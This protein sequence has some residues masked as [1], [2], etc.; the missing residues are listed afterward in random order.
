MALM[1]QGL[2]IAAGAGMPAAPTCELTRLGPL[3][4]QGGTGSSAPPGG[5]SS[6]LLVWAIALIGLALMLFL[7]EV[8]VPSGGLLGVASAIS[9]VVGVVLLFWENQV[10]GLVGAIVCLI[11]LPFLL[12]F[13]LKMWPNTPIGRVLMLSAPPSRAAPGEADAPTKA[14]LPNVT[15]GQRGRSV[16]ELRPVGTCVFDGK[17]EECLAAGGVIEPDTSVEVVAVDGRQIKVR[18]VRG[19]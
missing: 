17:R 1:M 11:A 15:V 2:A 5:D 14:G 18:P 13:A 6:A 19:A 3:L 4:A 10:L 9:A 12:G 16:S 8:F 7:I